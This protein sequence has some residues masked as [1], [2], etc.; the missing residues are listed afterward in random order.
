MTTTKTAPASRKR[1][2]NPNRGAKK[3]ERRGGRAKGTPNKVT[4]DVRALA[5]EYGAE[6]IKTLAEI[7]KDTAQPAAAR[8]SA[9][10]E[11]LDRAYGKSPQPV[12]DA[13]GSTLADAVHRLIEG[14]PS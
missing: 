4:A 13:D 8:V 11:I 9:V 7:M 14:L 5:Q 6:A 10:K 1:A 2:S 12:S 3:G